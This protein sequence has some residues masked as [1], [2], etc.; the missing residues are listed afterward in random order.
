[1]LVCIAECG[2]QSVWAAGA[3]AKRCDVSSH[4]SAQQTLW[5]VSFK[6]DHGNGTITCTVHAV[7]VLQLV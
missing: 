1:M 6:A 7:A 2:G 3:D 5:N 4:L